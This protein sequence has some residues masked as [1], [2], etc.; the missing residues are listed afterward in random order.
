MISNDF[1]GL[2][3]FQVKIF[4]VQNRHFLGFEF[5]FPF[6]IFGKIVLQVFGCDDYDK[7]VLFLGHD[8]LMIWMP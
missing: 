7:V 3:S 2:E 6:E 5:V 8:S 4:Q 1:K